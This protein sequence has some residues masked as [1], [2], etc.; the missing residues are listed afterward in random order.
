LKK[1]ASGELLGAFK[2][3]EQKMIARGI[4]PRPMKLDNEY[5]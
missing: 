3:V 5:S 2:V 4:K 1:I